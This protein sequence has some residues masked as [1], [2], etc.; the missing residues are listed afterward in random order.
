MATTKTKQVSTPEQLAIEQNEV[1]KAALITAEEKANRLSLAVDASDLAADAISDSWDEGD[2][3]ASAED[4]SLA[5]IEHKRATAL[6]Q[7]AQRSAQAIASSVIHTS[8][9]LAAVVAP[10]VRATYPDYGDVRVS[11]LHPTSPMPNPDHPYIT[12]V[13]SQPV[14]TGRGGAMSGVLDIVFTR[15]E[16]HRELDPRKIELAALK[17]GISLSITSHTRAQGDH[18]VDILHCVANSA[19]AAVP[20][21]YINPSK[22]MA[23]QF[24][25]G[26][27]RALCQAT[28][29]TTDPAIQ[30]LQG[31]GYRSAVVSVEATNGAIL[32]N[33][34]DASGKRLTTV[35]ASLKWASE[36]GVRKPEHTI[37]TYLRRIVSDQAGIFAEGL[38]VVTEAKIESMEFPNPLGE[39]SAVV[40]VT[41]ASVAR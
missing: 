18:V 28:R 13:Q 32:H 4:F 2:E 40:R 23:G 21:I 12:V 34:T 3:T 33:D 22:A 10:Y 24:A 8:T 19:H 5:Q 41:F 35:E 1:A 39:S 14:K 37:D 26:L 15:K 6:Y 7:A 11:F 17:D 36:R 9:E 20:V 30:M 31:G 27:A 25:Q 16:M 38:G 29:S